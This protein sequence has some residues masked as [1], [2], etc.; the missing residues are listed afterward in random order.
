MFFPARNEVYVGKLTQFG[1]VILR[2]YGNDHLPPHF[3]VL[4]PDFSA[5]VGISPVTILR[6]S[7]PAD[8]FGEISGWADSNR[9]RLISEWNLC[10]PRY[11]V[12]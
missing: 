12:V 9:D 8:V 7:V 4:A 6:G 5:L 10:N 2:V 3:H 11:P 1:N